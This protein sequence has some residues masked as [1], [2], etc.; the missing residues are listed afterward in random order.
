[1]KP[2][3][4]IFIAVCCLF[5]I[6]HIWAM[7]QRAV[8]DNNPY[9]TISKEEVEMLLSDVGKSNPEALR[10][11]AADP[12]LK[13]RQIDDLKEMLAFAS[14][15]QRQGLAADPTNKQELETSVPR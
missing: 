9:R 15:A 4:S 3:I 7:G 12:E 11:L 2:N 5:G 8:V 13:R 10:R 1:M 6:A 14:E